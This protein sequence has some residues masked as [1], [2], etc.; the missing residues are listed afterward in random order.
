MEKQEIQREA[1]QT[2]RHTGEDGGH[3]RQAHKGL[4]VAMWHLGKIP[5]TGELQRALKDV[6]DEVT[7]SLGVCWEM[8]DEADEMDKQAELESIREALRPFVLKE[9]DLRERVRR[10]K[11]GARSDG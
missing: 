5:D 1:L 7:R 2:C 10:A 8:R 4:G 11:E 9:S 3:W 6:L